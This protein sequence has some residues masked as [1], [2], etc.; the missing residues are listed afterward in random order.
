MSTSAKV[1]TQPQHVMFFKAEQGLIEVTLDNVSGSKAKK[2]SR[3]KT[4]L[5][6][7]KFRQRR[8]EREREEMAKISLLEEERDRYQRER[9]YYRDLTIE[10]Q[11]QLSQRP[12]SLSYRTSLTGNSN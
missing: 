7:Q 12:L 1:E 8:K 2:V 5:A 4:A 11:E 3:S 9:N 10:L 6:S